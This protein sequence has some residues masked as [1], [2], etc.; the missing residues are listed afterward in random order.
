MHTT[1]FRRHTQR[2]VAAACLAVVLPAVPAYA[3]NVVERVNLTWRSVTLKNLAS[4]ANESI[5]MWTFSSTSRI[6]VGGGFTFNNT[7]A[8]GTQDTSAP[9]P[10]PV[11]VFREG[12]T[13]EYTFND[14]CPCE[15]SR[16][17]THPY[18]GH[19]IHL[20]GLDVVTKED[21]VAE[22]SFSILPGQSYT[23][24]M[25]TRGAGSFIYHCHIHTVLHQQMGMYGAIV[26]MPA[27]EGDQNKPFSP[28]SDAER[29]LVPTFNKQYYWVIA[30]VDKEWHDK[31]NSGNFGDSV[32]FSYFTQYNPEHFVLANYHI[33]TNTMKSSSGDVGRG[34]VKTTSPQVT[35]RPGETLLLRIG[36]LGYLNHRIVLG[37]LK[38][39]VVSS[40]G[41]ALRDKNGALLPLVDKT[42]IDVAPGERY[43][44]IVKM[45]ATATTYNATVEF[46]DPYTQSATVTNATGVTFARKITQAIVV[47]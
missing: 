10:G 46:L 34:L 44:L 17:N 7:T 45:P 25:G 23:Y 14:T 5:P 41:K 27:A 42:S 31:A 4:G 28:K 20:H 40:D 33:D 13:V 38:F 12:D 2:I 30:E 29:S 3:V 32:E 1:K 35:A 43:D 8:R 36:N 16:S 21:G 9:F 39:N 11:L 37:G 47:Q 24:K 18:A 6:G 19:T 22:T 15:W 26:V